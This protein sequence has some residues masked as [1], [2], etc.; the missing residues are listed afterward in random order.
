MAKRKADH[1]AG[2]LREICE[3]LTA[4]LGNNGPR[5]VGVSEVAAS[6]KANGVDVTPEELD[7]AISIA[8]RRGTLKT[9]GDPPHSLSPALEKSTKRKRR[10]VPS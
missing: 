3:A 9:A 6:L 10:P 5:W 8:V 1:L 2:R 7:A 4:R